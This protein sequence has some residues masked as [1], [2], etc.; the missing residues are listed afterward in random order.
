MNI[1]LSAEKNLSSALLHLAAVCGRGIMNSVSVSAIPC[2]LN[3]HH[4]DMACYV[5]VY[6]FQCSLQ[7]GARTVRILLHIVSVRLKYSDTENIE[8]RMS[9]TRRHQYLYNMI[10]HQKRKSGLFGFM[11]SFFTHWSNSK[12][13][14]LLMVLIAP[15]HFLSHECCM[16][17]QSLANAENRS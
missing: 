8:L 10:I 16:S 14:I 5:E 11:V 6:M 4:R 1:S 9:T 2:S 7:C 3:N 12:S 17:F 13:R 15:C